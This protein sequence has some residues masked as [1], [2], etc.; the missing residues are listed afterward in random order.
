ML[1][2]D[3]GVGTE[4]QRRGAAMDPAAWCGPA[5][6]QNDAL[7]TEIH[8]DYARA[9]SDVITANTFAS[10]RVMLAAAGYGDHVA[11]LNTRAVEAALRAQAQLADEGRVVAVAGSLSH[12]MPMIPGTATV[13]RSLVP[14]AD[15]VGAA[16]VEVAQLVKDAGAEVILLEMMYEP[17]R[18]ALAVEA[19]LGVG[20]P[21][22]FGLSARRG[23]E[24][25]AVSFH[26]FD[27]VPLA[28]LARL[29]PATGI[30]V[31]GVMHTPSE[32]MSDA[33]RVVRDHFGGPLSAYPDSGHFE[34]PGWSFVDIIDPAVLERF[35]LAWLEQGARVLG[36]CCG[37]TIPHIEA[38]ARARAAWAA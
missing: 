3:G 17:E 1:L 11:E 15:A 26:H 8:V 36:G 16:F 25:E 21:V 6:L 28:E 27:E 4:L 37:L 14:S 32:L 7:L 10:S 33:L 9:G 30:D 13:D 34:M 12:L 23:A 19:A 29:I 2:L 22:W 20:L 24:G 5:T 38:A 35:Y 18:A 31:A